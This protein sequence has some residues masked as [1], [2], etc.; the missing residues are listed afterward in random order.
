MRMSLPFTV[1][2]FFSVFVAYNAAIWPAQIIAYTLGLIAVAALWWGGVWRNLVVLG[3]LAVMWAMN[4]IGYHL[5]FF[6]PVNPAARVFALA[7][8]LQAIIFAA[9][10]IGS[11]DLR[12]ETRS[13]F[14]TYAGLSFIGYASI[15]YGFLGYWTG[16]GFMSGPMFGVAPCP[17]T[18]FTLGVL[19]LMRGRLVNWLAIIPV[20]W[21]A[22]GTSAAIWLEVREDLGLTAAALSLLF[23]LGWDFFRE[24]RYR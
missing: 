3:V 16:H 4:G 20:L 19:I 2:Q 23:F 21:S 22:I 18:I 11:N 5:L 7:F 6:T 15:I 17:T 8:V 10:A 12:F 9:V 24:R 1:E 13:S 14:R